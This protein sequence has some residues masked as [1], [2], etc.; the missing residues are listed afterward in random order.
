MVDRLW[1][2]AQAE[3]YTA[4]RYEPSADEMFGSYDA[5]RGGKRAA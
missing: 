1:D 3:G 5:V 2:E 4:D